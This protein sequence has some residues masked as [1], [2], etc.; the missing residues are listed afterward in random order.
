MKT[1]LVSIVMLCGFAGAAYGETFSFK[2]TGK[3][4]NQM[5]IATGAD[6]SASANFQDTDATTT[7]ASGKT[8]ANKGQCASWSNPTGDQFNFT[9][10]C[11]FTEG[12]ADTASLEFSCI[13]D[14]PTSSDCWGAMRGVSGRFTGKTGS[15]LWHITVGE[16]NQTS[17]ANG[18]GMWN[19]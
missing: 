2:S 5:M 7:Y 16:D 4:T 14:S 8:I 6:S 9:G 17:S 18:A 12:S 19:D 13:S 11:T 3:V 15:I 1:M 10:I